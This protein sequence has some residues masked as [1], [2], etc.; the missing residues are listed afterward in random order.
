[1][2]SYHWNQQS[3][4]LHP[5]VLYHKINGIVEE[6]SLCFISSDLGHDVFFV[7]QVI[8]ATSEYIKNELC[9]NVH[10]IHYFSDGCSGQYKNC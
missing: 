2:Q 10:E 9:S 1:M 8:K 5:V 6:K 3:C 7:D 4:T